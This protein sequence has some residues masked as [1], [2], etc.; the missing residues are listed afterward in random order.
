MARW[1]A[2]CPP[3]KTSL[4]PQAPVDKAQ[5][6]FYD[7][8]GAKQSII[9]L[10]RPAVSALHPDYALL[11]AVNFRLGGAFTSELV[12]ELRTKRGYTYGVWSFFTGDQDRGTFQVSTSVR[13]NVT[14]ESISLIK[15]IVDAYGDDYETEDVKALIT[16]RTRRQAMDQETLD[17]KLRV[18]GNISAYDYP[19]DYQARNAAKLEAMSLEQFK[20]LVGAHML[21]DQMRYIIVGD[22]A[23]QAAGLTKLGLGE[24]IMLNGSTEP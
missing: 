10:E 21:P 2:P 4:P 19:T 20:S 5:L 3:E 6:Y 1:S 9:R 17:D 15:D 22:A 7:V 16:A 13:S 24:P 12:K 11:N 8:P 18:L 23:T 14:Q